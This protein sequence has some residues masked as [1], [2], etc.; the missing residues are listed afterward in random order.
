MVN[1]RE[2]PR[3]VGPWVTGTVPREVQPA[4]ELP[5][6]EPTG[7]PSALP[8][9]VKTSTVKLAFAAAELA[10]VIALTST[11]RVPLAIRLKKMA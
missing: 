6:P 4:V 5:G 8:V 7:P 11:A 1:R 2:T 3:A 10:V 9:R